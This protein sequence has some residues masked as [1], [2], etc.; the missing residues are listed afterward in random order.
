MTTPPIVCWFHTMHR[1]GAGQEGI[2]R[3]QAFAESAHWY[4]LAKSYTA[5]TRCVWEVA[6]SVKWGRLVY[7]R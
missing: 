3:Y 5:A 1:S 7:M 4:L 6:C 2:P